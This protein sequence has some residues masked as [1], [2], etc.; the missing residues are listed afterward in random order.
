MAEYTRAKKQTQ[1]RLQL[2]QYFPNQRMP[3]NVTI[4][5]LENTDA[6]NTA[7]ALGNLR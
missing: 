7:K 4:G 2:G 5:K 6:R 1:V 3:H